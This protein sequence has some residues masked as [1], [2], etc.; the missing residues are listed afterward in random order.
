MKT[1]NNE[2]QELYYHRLKR[3]TE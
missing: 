3:Q 1:S 2:R